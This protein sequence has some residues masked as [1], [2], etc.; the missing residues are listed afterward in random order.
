V[1]VDEVAELI[2]AGATGDNLGAEEFSAPSGPLDFLRCQ[3]RLMLDEGF[4][5]FYLHVRR[6][7]FVGII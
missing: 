7:R 5:P 2:C 3:F 1:E 4:A 6:P